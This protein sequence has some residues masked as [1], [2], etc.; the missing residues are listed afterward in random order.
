VTIGFVNGCAVLVILVCTLLVGLTFD[1]P[2]DG[3]LAFLV[4]GLVWA[5]ALL[6]VGGAARPVR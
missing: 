3:R 6:A 5:C 4:I 1:L 2:G